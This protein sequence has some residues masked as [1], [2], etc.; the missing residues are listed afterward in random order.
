MLK[1]TPGVHEAFEKQSKV[2]RRNMRNQHQVDRNI[3]S[4][5]EKHKVHMINLT[6]QH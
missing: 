2:D 1:Q 5:T 4:R 3:V 6:N